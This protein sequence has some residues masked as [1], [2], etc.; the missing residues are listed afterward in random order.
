MDETSAKKQCAICKKSG[1]EIKLQKCSICF[2]PFCEECAFTMSGRQFC[3][4]FCAE[5]FFFAQPDED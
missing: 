3:G 5:Y 4:H 2:K 1:E